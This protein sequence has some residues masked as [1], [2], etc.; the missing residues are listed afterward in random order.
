MSLPEPPIPEADDLEAN[1]RWL[2]DTA[3][4]KALPKESPSNFLWGFHLPSFKTITP[5][6]KAAL[7][8]V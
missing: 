4:I 1:V 8:P 7:L 3:L 6:K 5:K 2:R